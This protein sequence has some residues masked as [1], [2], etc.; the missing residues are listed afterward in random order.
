MKKPLVEIISRI[1]RGAAPATAIATSLAAPLAQAASGDLDPSFADHGR[2]GPITELKGSARS[3]E[4]LLEG[5][6]FLGGGGVEAHCDWYWCYYN[7]DFEASNFVSS[8]TE[9]GGLDASYG[10]S[11]DG[12]I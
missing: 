12:N 10:A 11:P 3:V 8:V 4:A 6:A 1:A 2:L 5:S 9:Q 7:V